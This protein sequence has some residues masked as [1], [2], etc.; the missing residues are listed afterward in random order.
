MKI[1]RGYEKR[2]KHFEIILSAVFQ[3]HVS[4]TKARVVRKVVAKAHHS[5]VFVKATS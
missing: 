5:L 3:W 1:I 2:R 4:F